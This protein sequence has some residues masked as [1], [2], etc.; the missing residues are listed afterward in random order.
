MNQEG[1]ELSYLL[2]KLSECPTDF[3]KE[4]Y[5]LKTGEKP[6]RLP[7]N[8]V[9]TIA[10]ISDLVYS[11]TKVPL[12][13]KEIEDMRTGDAINSMSKS[14]QIRKFLQ[15]IQICCYLLYEDCFQKPEYVVLIKKFLSFKKDSKLYLLAKMTEPTQ[16]LTD[17]ERREELSRTCLQHLN[18]RPKEET[19]IQAKDRLTTIDT[20][21][22][23]RVFEESKKSA[24]RAKIIRE[25]ME[26]KA[27]EEAASK[28]NRE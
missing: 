14:V 15:L 25:E 13:I 24:Q 20:V 11:I 17:P 12:S 22:R 10:L 7:E 27:A 4:P 16:F 5:I 2:H 3:Q 6:D 19:V 28:Y 26:R 9:N 23:Q 8:S 1:P 21:E 18:L